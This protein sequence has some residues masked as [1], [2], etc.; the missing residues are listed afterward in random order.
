MLTTEQDK[1]EAIQQNIEH[2]NKQIS[3]K[4]PLFILDLN[5][6]IYRKKVLSI[7]DQGIKT[8]RKHFKV[9]IE[10]NKI[11]IEFSKDDPK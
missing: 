6:Q 2:I 3:R 10:G 1:L 11:T 4:K 5:K 8:N 9:T 7:S